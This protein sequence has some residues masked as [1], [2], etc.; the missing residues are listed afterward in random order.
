MIYNNNDVL[1]HI[2][3][4]REA[5]E[6]VAE[7]AGYSTADL[8]SI[9]NRVVEERGKDSCDWDNPEEKIAFDYYYCIEQ[10]ARLTD[11]GD[12]SDKIRLRLF[13]FATMNKHVKEL[14][15]QAPYFD[16]KAFLSEEQI[17]AKVWRPKF[18]KK[19]VRK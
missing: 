12:L 15:D 7:S 5:F 19:G 3:A 4:L 6:I 10:H 9:R 11:T 18:G 16:P 2:D 1:E 8:T 13:R 17:S 14:W